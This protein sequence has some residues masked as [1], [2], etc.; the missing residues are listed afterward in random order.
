MTIPERALRV[1][2][3]EDHTATASALA[4]MLLRHGFEVASS[5]SAAAALAVARQQ[6]FDL[7]ITD[8]GLPEKNGWELFRELQALQP[9]LRAI[10]LTGYAYP[11][12]LLRSMDVGIQIHLIKPATADQL[13]SAIAELFP[14][15][16]RALDRRPA[17]PDAA[18]FGRR[19]RQ[20][21][22]GPL[23][24]LF[25]EDDRRDIELLELQLQRE[26][27]DCELTA[28][29]SRA[30]FVAALQRGGYGGIL[31]DSGVHDLFGADAVK[32]ARGLAPGIPYVFLCGIMSDT[33][34]ADL[35]AAKP[36]GLFSKDQ[37]EDVGSAIALLRKLSADRAS[38]PPG[39]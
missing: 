2:V 37:P 39:G 12:D 34:R 3:V 9:G 38:P 8:I 13:R 29:G 5:A 36:D 31:S 27:P 17:G 23:K 11:D 14:G 32:L 24:L 20:W 33:K 4:K 7:L 10:A 6:P 35:L 28:V 26:E 21:S 30:D 25:L 1:L 15:Q 19:S 18:P 16:A 22:R